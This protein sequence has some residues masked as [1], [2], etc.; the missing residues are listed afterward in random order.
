MSLQRS[1]HAYEITW[2]IRRL[3]RA[4]AAVAD[5]YLADTG[6]SAADR[7]VMEFLHPR[8]ELSVP[9]I[10]RRY[11]VSRQHVQVTIN[12]LV[13]R[14][15]VRS[16]ENPQHKRSRLMRLS[17]AGRMSFQE[18]R[19]SEAA[20]IEETFSDISDDALETTRETLTALLSKLG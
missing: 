6:L 15:L 4:M 18:I 5:Q 19:R 3:F 8:L 10:A 7:A 11:N 16:V 13:A 1:E 12:A 20:V 17:N 2:L 14:G 9:E